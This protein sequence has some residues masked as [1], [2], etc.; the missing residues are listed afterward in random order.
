MVTNKVIESIYK[1][2]KKRP[3]SPD[4]LDIALLFDPSMDAHNIFIDGDRLIIN[5]IDPKSPFHS[6]LLSRI[7]QILNFE[8]VVAIVLHSSIIFLNKTDNK[9]HIHV[10]MP[11][12]SWLDRLRLR[13]DGL[14]N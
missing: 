8:N 14:D 13:K 12:L 2:Y 9:V 6:I 5:S 3:A 11:E 4:E 1:K 7:H 10:K